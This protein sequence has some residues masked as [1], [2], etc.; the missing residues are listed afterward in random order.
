MAAQTDTI[1]RL[2]RLEKD[3]KRSVEQQ[4][5]MQKQTIN[6]RFTELGNLGGGWQ[7]PFVLMFLLFC[8]GAFMMYRY[9]LYLRKT[10]LL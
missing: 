5:E 6:T 3:L 9:H 1:R 4:L 2:E 8:A 10:H 7:I